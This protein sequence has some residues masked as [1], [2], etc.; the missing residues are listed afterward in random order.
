MLLQPAIFDM[1]TVDIKCITVNRTDATAS[2]Y[3]PIL[4][5]SHSE[6]LQV[7]FDECSI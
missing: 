6:A 2:R 1:T 7:I 3:K 5:M 4:I